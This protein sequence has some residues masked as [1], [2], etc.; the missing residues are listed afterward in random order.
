M[1]MFSVGIWVVFK[2]L[3]TAF[4]VFSKSWLA[5]DIGN[6]M[7]KKS[8]C[9]V[10]FASALFMAC[11]DNADCRSKSKECA[12][13]FVC[14]GD[15]SGRWDCIK[16]KDDDS[17]SKEAPVKHYFAR[18]GKEKTTLCIDHSSC[19]K[20]TLECLCNEKKQLVSLILDRDGDGKGDEKAIYQY[21][22]N[23]YLTFIIIDEGMD[24][25]DDLRH[26]YGY[27]SADAPTFRE[28]VR[29]PEV[30]SK[31][32]NSRVEYR[33]NNEGNLVFERV[34]TGIDGIFERRC[35]YN[36]PCPPPIPNSKCRPVCNETKAA[37]PESTP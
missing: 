13:G 37:S 25:I 3:Y 26:E 6:A 10:Y 8:F 33:Y 18:V 36:P 9:I 12:S 1:Y 20:G 24:G 4:D 27:K 35:V 16:S 11:G 7:K 17:S 28:I 30:R 34:D 21:N 15:R 2:L 5:I 31:L 32:P 14:E 29:N 19:T 22:Q 23:D